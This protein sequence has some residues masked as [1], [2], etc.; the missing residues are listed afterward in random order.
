[1]NRTQAYETYFENLM[2][3]TDKLMQ[4]DA[5]QNSID[6]DE[7]SAVST[8]ENEYMS[9]SDELQKAKKTVREQ[10]RS[11]LDSCAS[12]AGLRKPN[13]QRPLRT[14]LNWQDAV[15]LQEQAAS[16]I[17]DWITVKSQQAYEARQEKVRQD[18]QRE[19]AL[20]AA[21]AEAARK[22]AAETARLEEERAAALVE[23]LKKKH[24]MKN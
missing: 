7:R 9:L 24:R 10:Y 14:E 2:E 12:N 13:D 8:I 16:R 21:R 20:A 11:V 23:E 15:R 1:M 5:A 17:R 3:I 6:Q 19:A 22:K 18:K 4:I